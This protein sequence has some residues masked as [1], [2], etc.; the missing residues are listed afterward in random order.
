VPTSEAAANA[1]LDLEVSAG[2]SWW[3]SFAT[4]DLDVALTVTVDEAPMPRVELPRDG[5]TTWESADVRHV[6]PLAD[7]PMG[8][9]SDDFTPT[10]WVAW[11]AETGGTPQHAA[12]V[13]DTQVLAG[14][15]VVI[16]ADTLTLTH[17]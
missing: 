8:V 4:N 10:F 11:D 14:A 1:T 6:R 17:P 15:T 9:A 7:L 13:P 16:P 3:I 12:R 2:G 5:A